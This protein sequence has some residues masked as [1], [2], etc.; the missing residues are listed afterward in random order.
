MDTVVG[1]DHGATATRLTASRVDDAPATL[2]KAAQ[3]IQQDPVAAIE[4][5]AAIRNRPAK[6]IDEESAGRADYL[7]ARANVNLGNLDI[8][9]DCIDA[10]ARH[11]RSADLPID[12]LRTDLGRMHVLDDLGR[13]AEAVTIGCHLLDALDALGEIGNDESSSASYLHAAALENLGVSYGY[14]GRTAEALESYAAAEPGYSSIGDADGALRC[15]ANRG[16]ELTELARSDE[17]IA[18]LTEAGAGF[19]TTDD[20]LSAAKC[21]AYASRAHLQRGDFAASLRAADEATRLLVDQDVTTEYARTQLVAA[22]TLASLNLAEDAVELYDT[23]IERFAGCGLRRDLAAALDGRARSMLAVGDRRGALA[24]FQQ[25]LDAIDEPNESVAAATLRIG[26]SRC[27]DG[28]EAIEMAHRALSALRGTGRPVEE[29]MVLIRL[30]E[31]SVADE[32]GALVDRALT[33]IGDDLPHLSWQVLRLQAGLS[34]AAGAADEARSR[35]EQADRII[36]HLRGSV[37]D[38][39]SRLRF[40]GSRRAVH[41]DLMRVMLASGETTAAF[42][43]SQRARARTLV[44]RVRDVAGPET[45]DEPV[46]ASEVAELTYEILDDEIVAFLRRG[47]DLQVVRHLTTTAAVGSLLLRLDAQWRRFDSPML[48]TRMADGSVTATVDLLQQ[49]YIELIGDL[50]TEL[51]GP[52]LMVIPTGLL[53]NVPF[54]ALHDGTQHLLER[55]T[56]GIHPSAMLAPRPARPLPSNARRLVL[57]VADDH[58]PKIR[59]EVDAIR[60]FGDT[61]ALYDNDATVAALSA[62]GPDHDV[63]HLACHGINRPGAPHLSAI[64]LGDGWLTA[65]DIAGMQFSGQLVV[66]SACSSGRQQTLG[67]ADEVVGLPRAFLAAGASGVIVNHWRADD[68]VSSELMTDVHRLLTGVDAL[69]ALRSAQLKAFERHPHPYFWAPGFGYGLTPPQAREGNILHHVGKAS[70]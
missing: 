37:A 10:A 5:L 45:P 33:L 2:A 36:E 29:V 35:L 7:A 13:S 42:E 21:A 8:A 11:F 63:I 12:A 23:L 44:E 59:D 30:I 62:L 27:L 61:T 41:V 15:Q 65:H 52:S 26:M 48:A 51:D 69:S 25:A 43:R 34:L 40:L 67:N 60:A 3:L 28:V 22:D 9:L 46:P 32:A 16:V 56:V 55:A 24:S 50:A 58:A 54:S 19:L 38:E 6:P 47:T 17:A 20:L 1:R 66:L 64:R 14:L 39:R 53:T 31:L 49:L 68:Q 18:A 4:V 70:P 57:G